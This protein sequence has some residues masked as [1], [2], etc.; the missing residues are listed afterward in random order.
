MIRAVLDW[1]QANAFLDFVIFFIFTYVLE[2]SKIKINP[3]TWF[4][5][6]LAAAINHDVMKRLDDIDERIDSMEKQQNEDRE[7]TKKDRAEDARTRLLRAADEIRLDVKHSQE[8][9]DEVLRD[10]AK[11]KKYCD[12]HD[13]YPNHKAEASIKIINETYERCMKEN[14]FL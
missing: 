7:Q 9:F 10:C 11:Y 3:W 12:E 8:F 14:S 5:Q 13:T 4:G 1:I 6:K 2:I